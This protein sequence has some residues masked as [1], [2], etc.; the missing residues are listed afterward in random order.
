MAS[1]QW[2]SGLGGGLLVTVP[3]PQQYALPQTQVD[4]AVG[5]ALTE[6]AA[7]AITG[8]RLTPWLLARV[9]ELTGGESVAANRALLLN[10]ATIAARI[11]VALADADDQ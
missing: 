8:P 7:T 3:L 5:Q 9:A 11:A 2:R 1:A 4:A 6:A 10:N